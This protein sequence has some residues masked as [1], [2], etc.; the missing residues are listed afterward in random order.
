MTT[1][2]VYIPVSTSEYARIYGVS[3]TTARRRI[4]AMDTSYKVG[5]KWSALIP[6]PEYARRSGVNIKAVRKRKSSLRTTSPVD[7]AMSLKQPTLRERAVRNY[8]WLLLDDPERA[9]RVSLRTIESRLKHANR[10]Q[11]TYLENATDL[12]FSDEFL[13]R[14]WMG[15]DNE[16]VL[17]YK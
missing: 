12:S 16:S 3:A 8:G 17:Y 14:F 11:L 10:K 4:A 13:D 7:T 5:T 6:A 15:N 1:A 2:K 9:R